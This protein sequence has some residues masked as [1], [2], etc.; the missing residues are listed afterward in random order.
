[1]Q[2]RPARTAVRRAWADIATL[3]A[4]TVP[5]WKIDGLV[6]RTHRN[7]VGACKCYA[8]SAHRTAL[9]CNRRRNR[10][11]RVLASPRGREESAFAALGDS[12]ETIRTAAVPLPP[13]SRSQGP[14]EAGPQ[15]LDTFNVEST[16]DEPMLHPG[17]GRAPVRPRTCARWARRGPGS[18]VFSALEYDPAGRQAH[19]DHLR[20]RVKTW[21]RPATWTSWRA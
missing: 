1:M 20:Q 18:D 9:I 6:K 2:R 12:H 15:A 5:T 16:A 10:F 21:P 19:F 13:S 7:Q 17:T 4:T 11:L 8:C 14:V 3:P